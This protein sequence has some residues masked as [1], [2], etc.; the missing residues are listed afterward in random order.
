MGHL[1]RV[2]A[3]KLITTAIQDGAAAAS[4]EATLGY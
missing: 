1:D 2:R 4:I 3:T